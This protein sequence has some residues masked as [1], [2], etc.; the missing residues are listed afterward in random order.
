LRRYCDLVTLMEDSMAGDERELA[1]IRQ[2]MLQRATEYLV[3]HGTAPEEARRLAEQALEAPP[4]F[5]IPTI[6]ELERDA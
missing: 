1:A 4:R 6:E 5:H 3:A 2:R